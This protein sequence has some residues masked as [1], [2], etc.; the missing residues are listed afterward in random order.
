M[1]AILE[2]RCA[3]AD[4]PEVLNEKKCY[5]PV[6]RI[7]FLR[8]GRRS[9]FIWPRHYCQDLAAYPPASGGP[10]SGAGICGI[11]ACKV[12]PLRPLPAGAVGSYPAFS[13]SPLPF[14]RRAGQLFSVA[15]SVDV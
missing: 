10:P 11:S 15:L 4:N 14:L 12:Y 13:T 5:Q 6:S 2:R 8:L 1:C 7:L 3:G 9:S